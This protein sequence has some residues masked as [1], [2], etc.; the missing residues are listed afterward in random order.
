MTNHKN[1]FRT[2]FSA[3]PPA[4]AK[5]LEISLVSD[6]S[7]VRVR[8]CNYSQAQRKFLRNFATQLVNANMAYLNPSSAWACAPLLVPKDGP[9]EFRF[10]DDLR[11]FNRFT[12]KHQFSM[13]IL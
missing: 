1:V 7:P 2:S 8:L 12:V 5:P 6:A 9:D 4:K 10:T 3:G 11:P 13:P